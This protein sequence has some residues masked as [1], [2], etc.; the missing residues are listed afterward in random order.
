MFDTIADVAQPAERATC[1]R[2]VGGSTPPVGS[3]PFI[4]P[5][6][7][8]P[9]AWLPFLEQS[10]LARYFSNGGPCVRQIEAELQ[11]E[12]GG[13]RRAVLTASGTAGLTA[14][15]LA[16]DCK[17]TV[18][19]PAFTFAATAQSV[20]AAGCHPVLC[21]VSED[22]WELDPRDLTHTLGGLFRHAKPAA[23]I[24]V[25]TFG[26]CRD[27]ERIEDIASR[28]SVPLIVD[29]AAALGGKLP[30][31]RHAGCQGVAE[32]FSLHATKPFGVGEGGL[33][34]TNPLLAERVRRAINFGLRDGDPAM[35]GINGK[36]SEFHAAVGLAMLRRIAGHLAIRASVA[37]T[38]DMEEIYNG[39]IEED[40][41]YP[42]WQLYPTL[43][44]DPERIIRHAAERGIELRRYY[45]PALHRSRHF[46]EKTPFPVAERLADHMLCL[47]IYSDMTAAEQARVIET[48][49]DCQD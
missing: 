1:T 11:A 6:L 49:N 20:L 30:D 36:M 34:M 31:G 12:F 24:H 4:R 26:F 43:V 29:S 42:P 38:Y 7:P 16:L 27:L 32:V 3:L 19:V 2:L 41:G 37:L 48:L 44:S 15:L 18:I 46:Y 45:R 22:T 39:F 14:T 5:C 40:I 10:Y 35:A 28:Y 13:E 8:P 21:D 23:I 47:P 17:G 9:E 25:R 33:V